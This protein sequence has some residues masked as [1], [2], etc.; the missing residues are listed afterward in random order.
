LKRY[1][2]DEDSLSVQSV[3][4]GEEVRITGEDKAEDEATFANSL[5]VMLEKE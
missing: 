4:T 1:Q 2:W 5:D 3:G